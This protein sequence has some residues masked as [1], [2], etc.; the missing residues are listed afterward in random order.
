MTIH[1]QYVPPIAR[2]ASHLEEE[3]ILSLINS[4]V[5]TT[6]FSKQ[7][8]SKSNLYTSE[9]DENIIKENLFH[10]DATVLEHLLERVQELTSH[11]GEPVFDPEA[12]KK[13]GLPSY[14]SFIQDKRQVLRKMKHN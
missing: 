3:S 5:R 9:D 10:I 7:T 4:K 8:E 1:R 2:V 13:A 11:R 6:N 14:T 12:S